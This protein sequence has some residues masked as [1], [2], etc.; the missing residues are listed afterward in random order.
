LHAKL[1]EPLRLWY[2]A[3]GRLDPGR[4]SWQLPAAGLPPLPAP[5]ADRQDVALLDRLV[6]SLPPRD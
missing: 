1:A 6:A 4:V 3:V 5:R 2:E